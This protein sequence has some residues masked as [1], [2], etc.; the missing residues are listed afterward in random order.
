MQLLLDQPDHQTWETQD[1]FALSIVV[2]EF[3]T[4]G[5]FTYPYSGDKPTPSYA[6]LLL[7]ELEVYNLLLQDLKGIYNVTSLTGRL[8]RKIKLWKDRIPPSDAIECT[9]RGPEPHTLNPKPL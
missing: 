6:Q 7:Y 8:D 3:L 4:F 9:V 5:M 2:V 1:V